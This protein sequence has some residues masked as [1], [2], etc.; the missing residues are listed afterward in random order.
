MATEK[1]MR[2]ETEEETVMILQTTRMKMNIIQMMRMG[3]PDSIETTVKMRRM[4]ATLT[5]LMR[6]MSTLKKTQQNAI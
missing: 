5:G 4:M 2:T 6:K 1:G 3:T